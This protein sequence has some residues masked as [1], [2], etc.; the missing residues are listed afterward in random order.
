MPN[1]KL[2]IGF[3]IPQIEGIRGPGVR[4][5]PELLE[6]SKVAEDIGMDSLWISDHLIYQLEGEEQGRGCWEVWSLLSALAASTQRVE[7]GT[8]VLALGW[9]NPA[10]LAKMADTVEEISG[11]RL[12][13]GLGAGY[14]KVEYDAFGFPFD[15]RVSRFEEGIQ[16]IRGLLRDGEIDFEGK[17][18]SAR[19]CELRPRGPRESGPPILMGTI[20]PRMLRIAARYADAWNAYYDDVHNQVEGLD[21]LQ[22]LVDDACKE[23]GRDPKTMERTV[24]LLLADSSADPWWDRL[25]VEQLHG[26]GPLVPITGA[27][28]V[29]AE[30][31]L[32]YHGRGV[33]HIQICLEPTTAKTVE[34]LS[35]V[36]EEVAKA[37]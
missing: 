20:K 34:A 7:L 10:L 17:F 31:F 12:I 22:P 9:R 1:D 25:P 2:K 3:Q 16:I 5:W 4:G 35:A 11:G 26:E 6:I 33:S 36:L 29:I 23:E 21:R 32:A 37:S 8:L 15:Y 28:E 19:D 13:L 18:Y 14:H 27:P 30:Q 24:T